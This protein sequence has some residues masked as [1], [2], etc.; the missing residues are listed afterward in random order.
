MFDI[1]IVL[2]ALIALILS[3]VTAFLIPWLKEK[4][5]SEKIAKIFSIV[6]EVVYAA[7]ELDITGELIQMGI[8]KVDYAWAE[9]KKILANKKLTVDDDELKAYIKGEVAKLRVARG[10]TLI[11]LEE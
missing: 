11:V 8:T 9:T 5:K 10:D 4:K 6:E 3:L 2:K 7:W 1:T